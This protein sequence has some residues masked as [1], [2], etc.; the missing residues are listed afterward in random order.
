MQD[1]KMEKEVARPY[2]I[3][4]ARHVTALAEKYIDRLGPVLSAGDAGA[5]RAFSTFVEHILIK[6]AEEE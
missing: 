4:Q 5:I 6:E 1:R 3:S 2:L